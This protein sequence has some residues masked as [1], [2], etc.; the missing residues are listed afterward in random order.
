[1][2][3][4]RLTTYRKMGYTISMP[5]EPMQKGDVKNEDQDPCLD[6]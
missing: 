5:S 3:R 1:M 6:L 2:F 4:K